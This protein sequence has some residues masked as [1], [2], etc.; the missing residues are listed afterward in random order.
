MPKSGGQQAATS[1]RIDLDQ[2]AA[3]SEAGDLEAGAV[4]GVVR[5]LMDLYQ[6]GHRGSFRRQMNELLTATAASQ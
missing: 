6:Q 2:L 5:D 3:A 4:L 1:H